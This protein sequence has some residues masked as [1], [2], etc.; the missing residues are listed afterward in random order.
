MNTII[1]SLDCVRTEALSC[2]PESFSYRHRAPYRAETP[3]IDSIASDGILFHN[4]FCQAP[5][6]PASHA[7]LFTGQNPYQHGIRGMFSYKL[8]NNTET[9]AERF[10]AAGYDT[11]GFIGAH[12]LSSQYGLDSGFDTY[13][14]EFDAT[15][16]NWVVGNRR[17]CTEVTSQTLDWLDERDDKYLLF[18]HYF[19]A[20][21]GG[22]T[23]DGYNGAGDDEEPSTSGA[24]GFYNDYVRSLDEAVGAPVKRVYRM[25][26]KLD[27]YYAYGRR[28]Q[29]LQVHRIDK[30][31]GHLLET[32][33]DR[34]DYEETT[35]VILADHGDS[36]GTHGEYGHRKYIY[37][38]TIRVPLIVKPADGTHP[39][40]GTCDRVVRSIDVYPTLAEEAGVTTGTV[41][42]ESLYQAVTGD[43]ERRTA[44][45]ETR[46][47]RSPNNL[48]DLVTD[49]VGIRNRRWKLIYDQL[50]DSYELYDV[51]NDPGEQHDVAAEFV[52]VC[53]DFA[54][55]LDQLLA[56][57]PDKE[58]NL[59]SDA[60]QAA[61]ED[62]LEGLGYL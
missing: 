21:D 28:Y 25:L 58:T 33:H 26:R 46:L 29:L 47:E 61:V 16:D 43:S 53:D 20:H 59:M 31:V 14:E 6:T 36:F 24:R 44:Y 55:K 11:G 42:G 37:D 3:Y 23:L 41:E 50:D 4:A 57:A 45:A 52:D 35:I 2:Y 51:E 17:P 49:L 39:G 18:L 54:A 62:H 40:A 12:A 60:E 22:D 13:D 9:M 32:L 34:G 1:I 5:F 48:D 27:P 15:V 10:S 38:T 56:N 30:Q 8:N 7:S 19:D